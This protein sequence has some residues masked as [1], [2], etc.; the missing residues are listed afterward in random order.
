MD[1]QLVRG[2]VI[3]EVVP[4]NGG[5]LELSAHVLGEPA[6]DLQTADALTDRGVRAYLGDENVLPRLQSNS[7]NADYVAVYSRNYSL[8][9]SEPY[10]I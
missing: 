8:M 9:R 5:E 1:D 2:G 6:G 10:D 4:L 7:V 3:G